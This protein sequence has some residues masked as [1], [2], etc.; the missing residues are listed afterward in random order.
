MFTKVVYKCQVL[1]RLIVVLSVILIS[2]NSYSQKWLSKLPENKRE[3]SLTLFDYQDAF[4]SYWDRYDVQNGYF[5]NKSGSRQKIPGWKLFKRWEYY[6]ESRV[7]RGTGVFPN[8]SA[9]DEYNKWKSRINKIDSRSLSGNWQ[10]LGPSSSS[11]GYAGTGRLN[12][13]A[14]HPDDN[15]TYWVGS[16]SG[17]IWKTADDGANWIV[18]SDDNEVLGVSDIAVSSGYTN[19]NTIYIATGDRDG[20]SMWSLGGGQSNDNNSIGVLKSEDGGSTWN[21]TGLTFTVDQKRKV[22]RLLIDPDN[23]DILYAATSVGVYK[24]TDGGINWNQK[25]GNSFNDMEF[26][27]GEST[28]LYGSDRFG[29]VYR[30]TDSGS[31]WTKNLDTDFG[32][33]ELAVSPANPSIVYVVTEDYGLG[34]IYRSTDSGTSFNLIYSNDLNLLG[35]N[36]DGND[37]G[38]QGWY[39]LCIASDP[40]DAD[41]VFVGGINTWKSTDGGSTWSIDTHWSS[42]CSGNATTVH[43]DKH[44]LAYQ[45]GTNALFQCNDGGI[46]KTTDNGANWTDKSNG[47]IHSQI[48]RLGISQTES[49]ASIIGLQD[50]GTKLLHTDGVWYDVKGGD[51]MECIIDFNDYNTQYR[52]YVEGDIARTTDVWN[53]TD[54]TKDNYGNWINGIDAAEEGHWVTPYVIDPADHNTLYMGLKDLWKSTN[55]GDAWSKISNVNTSQ[56]LRSVAI[57]PS[58]SG[59]LYIA[60][61]D[62]LWA[63]SNGGGTWQERTA[64]LPVSSNSITYIAVKYDDPSTVWVTFGG[65][66]SDRVYQSIDAGQNWVD[67]SAGLPDLPVMSI[68]HNKQ[69]NTETELY[70]GTD[71]GVYVK[72]GTNNWEEYSNGLPNVVIAELE[73]YYDDND[74]TNSKLRAGSFGRGLWESD[75]RTAPA[76]PMVYQSST[77]TQNNTDNLSKGDL[78]QEIVGIQIVTQGNENPLEITAFS[79]NTNGSSNPI[80]DIDIAKVYFTGTSNSF[81]TNNLFS[82][83]TN[84]NGSF[85]ANGTQTLSMGTNYFWLTYDIKPNA[86]VGDVVD[87]ECLDITVGGSMESPTIT[88]PAGERVI[89]CEYCYSYG[90]NDW[91]T[92]TTGVVFNS[93]D[94][95]SGKQLD[96]NG[97]AYSDYTNLS[98]DVFLNQIYNMTVYVNTDGAVETKTKVW[99][100]WNSDC[101]YDDSNEEYDLGMAYN[102]FDEATSSSPLQ[103]S[104][105]NGALLG[106]TRMRVSTK[107]STYAYNCETDFDGEV[108]EYSLRI[109]DKVTWLG[110]NTNWHDSQNWSNGIVPDFSY[111]VTIPTTPQGGQ[112]PI[113]E[114]GTQ[115]MCYGLILEPN[116]TIN[117]VGRLETKE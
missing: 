82:T 95:G 42:T 61:P 23:N 4:Y 59:Y 16:P 71:I 19:D 57:A 60:D 67:I 115:A 56:K 109:I 77:T 35:W 32:R 12:C 90:N 11:G 41:I 8:T 13:V 29:D 102:V 14:F 39:D 63:T 40:T 36:C 30:S 18:L 99:I 111:Q 26:K 5:V 79:F 3:E 98:T 21:A 66:D 2:I 100:D 55:Q 22:S 6:W 1:M 103:I 24:T 81:N 17:G 83:I 93:I 96:G 116:A 33:A 31:N 38:D 87:A 113:V 15:N 48:Y 84:P 114:I 64:G 44:F 37:S 20:G 27:P 107:Y 34:G 54:I 74:Q 80:G 49:N 97:N 117:V 89:V 76:G 94:N 9:I 7:D 62:Q 69:N 72:V 106:T 47:I 68:V 46:Y 110:N 92:S 28:T 108:E 70:V 88:S 101:D 45:D 52:C 51:G 91:Q 73:I 78:N 53:N 43:A 85:V 65:Y 58:N 75:L 10:S 105:P 86:N 25:T 50:N 104:I 112:F